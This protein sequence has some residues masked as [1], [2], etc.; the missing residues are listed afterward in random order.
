[1]KG[2]SL[3]E[4]MVVIAI[5]ALL[6]A[7]A[8]PV[9]KNHLYKAKINGVISATHSFGVK[10]LDYYSKTG[11]FPS[12]PTVLGYPT[13]ATYAGPIAN[14]S[15]C[16][17]SSASPGNAWWGSTYINTICITASG[18]SGRIDTMVSITAIGIPVT[19]PWTDAIFSQRWT[20]SNGVITYQCFQGGGSPYAAYF[21]AN[22]T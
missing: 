4:L 5:V 17:T 22:C 3:I 2:F 21:P 16:L 7:V 12:D 20:D 18:S 1:M 9:Y 11:S 14:Q 8:V 6:A 13:S 19:S 10:I 15:N